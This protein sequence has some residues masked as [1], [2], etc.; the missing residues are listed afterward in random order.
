MRTWRLRIAATARPANSRGRGALAGRSSRHCPT[1]SR[2]DER[3]RWRL[4]DSHIA[5]PNASTS[6]RPDRRRS[7]TRGRIPQSLRSGASRRAQLVACAA[8]GVAAASAERAVADSAAIKKHFIGNSFGWILP[9]RW[10]MPRQRYVSGLCS[11]PPRRTAG[12]K[13]SLCTPVGRRVT[14]GRET[15]HRG[16]RDRRGATLEPPPMTSARP[17]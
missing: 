16:L 13:L 17:T 12:L 10:I 2:T 11:G 5:P 1:A 8:A 6:C 3:Q 4:T 7:P 15:Q 14:S 9:I